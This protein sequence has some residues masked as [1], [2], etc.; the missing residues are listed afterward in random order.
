MKFYIEKPC[1]LF[2]KYGDRDDVYFAHCISAD[3]AIGGPAY[4]NV[5]TRINV[6]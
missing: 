2:E 5:G 1:N 4:I 3:C 6:Y